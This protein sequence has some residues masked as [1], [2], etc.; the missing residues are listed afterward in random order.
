MSFQTTPYINL[1]FLDFLRHV[2]AVSVHRNSR[3]MDS[4]MYYGEFPSSYLFGRFCSFNFLPVIHVELK[5]SKFNVKFV[6]SYGGWV[7]R[8]DI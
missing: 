6:M 2:V 3:S 4:G 7:F 5:E 1:R 8:Y